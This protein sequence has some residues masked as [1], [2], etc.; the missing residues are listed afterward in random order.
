MA[1]SVWT[2]CP[3]TGKLALA[4][5]CLLTCNEIWRFATPFFDVLTH[6]STSSITVFCM[7]LCAGWITWQTCAETLFGCFFLFRMRLVESHLGR[8]KFLL[9]CFFASFAHAVMLLFAF[10]LPLGI[11]SRQLSKSGPLVLYFSL[12]SRYFFEIPVKVRFSVFTLGIDNR[13]FEILL[14]SQL[15]LY[16]L[17]F[18][19]IPAVIGLLIGLIF[20]CGP[21]VFAELPRMNVMSSMF[22][23]MSTMSGH[24]RRE[25]ERN[26]YP[27]VSYSPVQA[28]SG[29]STSE[30]GNDANN[31]DLNNK[32]SQKNLTEP[33]D[34]GIDEDSELQEAIMLSLRKI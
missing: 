15:L 20:K 30:H 8:S 27:S 21:H 10:F 18:S 32:Q 11:E 29:F 14:G 31:A 19:L 17:P 3:V 13:W 22:S 28:S 25:L 24:S 23:S 6:F 33:V 12:L 16:R 5:L 7:T 26:S 2:A 34:V 4:S 1:A 9:L